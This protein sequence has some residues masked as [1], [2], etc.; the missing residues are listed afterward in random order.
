MVAAGSLATVVGN[1]SGN[2]LSGQSGAITN[3]DGG[4]LPFDLAGA[5]VTIAGQA[6]KIIQASPTKVDFIVPDGVPAGNQEVLVTSIDGFVSEGTINVTQAT[7]ALF[8]ASGN[9]IGEGVIMNAVTLQPGPFD[10]T[11]GINP[12][13][14]KRTRLLLLAT[15]ISN[16]LSNRT[17]S[18]D[19]HF[20]NFLLPNIADAVS[21]EAKTTDGRVFQLPVEYA[22][23][24]GTAP[25]LDEVIVVLPAGMK[26]AGSVSVTVVT[27]SVRSNSVGVTIR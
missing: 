9:G 23:P 5:S 6:A 12:G 17:A 4:S 18:N 14:D 7:P 24:Q 3:A 22:G 11:T 27:G 13:S 8:S 1:S 10:V 16:G 2:P 19:V 21:V 26:G 20:G 15:G 25:G